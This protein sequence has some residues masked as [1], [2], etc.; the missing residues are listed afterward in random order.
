MN[1]SGCFQLVLLGLLITDFARAANSDLWGVA[2]E[3]WDARSRLPDF[4]HA[5][6]H[7]GETPLPNVAPGVSVKDFGAKGDGV[8][9]DSEAFLAALAAVTN[10]AVEV[11]AGRYR[12]TKI[13][14]IKRSGL[15]LRG[16]G[17][18]K[19]VLFFPRPLNDIKPD[20]GKT[21]DDRRTS[22]YSWSGGFVWFRGDLGERLL[23]PVTGAAQR[24]DTVLRVAGTNLLHVGQR[25]VI[26]QQDNQDNSLATELYSNE[27]GDIRQLRGG[28][29]AVLVCRVLKIS[30][31]EI[32]CDR[33][34]RCDV[35]MEW[36]PCIQKFEPTVAESGV[37]NI[38]FAFPEL[39]YRGHF[40]E[41]GYNAVAFSGVADCWARNLRIVNADSGFH[42]GG[43]FCTVQGVVLASFRKPDAKNNTG[44]HGFSF[45]GG[46]DNLFK[47]F[48]FETQFIHDISVD[49]GAAGNVSSTGRGVDLCFD[50][51]KRSNYENLFVNIDVG[52]GTH[53]WRH[54]GGGGLGKPCA[55]R[56]AFWNIRAAH[57]LAYP[58][59]DFGPDSMS[60]VAV[61]TKQP[62]ETNLTGRWFEVIPPADIMPQDIHAAQLAR[63]LGR[64]P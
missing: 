35:R 56:G 30:G 16:A 64:A 62:S 10:G 40:T 54:G 6:Y 23:T 48:N 8:A 17:P 50:H 5:G 55:A 19:S 63:R 53:L 45:S 12:I 34:L 13:L 59:A 33:P 18:D 38:C 36:K 60:L 11:P 9:D 31:N 7:C 21:T 42:L 41:L 32:T 27:P 39:P 22:N 29:R 2:G 44:H 51:H 37:E 25:I 47:D 24:G 26:R 4:S 57:P 20:W 28:T 52:A 14:E 3:R 49:G 15:V 43:R 61:Q 46:Q 1:L 58:P